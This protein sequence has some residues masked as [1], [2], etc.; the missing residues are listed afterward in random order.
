M[1]LPCSQTG[2]A[3]HTCACPAQASLTVFLRHGTSSG[4]SVFP[5]H[6]HWNHLPRL[7][8]KPEFLD[9]H[10]PKPLPRWFMM[11]GSILVS[12]GFCNKWPPSRWLKTTDIY[13]PLSLGQKSEIKMS[14][15]ASCPRVLW[16]EGRLAFSGTFGILW[17]VVAPSKLCLGGHVVFLSSLKSSFCLCLVVGCTS[18]LQGHPGEIRILMI[19]N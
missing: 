10:M 15:K 16:G 3:S 9:L 11:L 18:C 2:T 8:H 19:F 7:P 17:F 4:P 5:L 6:F 12:C 1:M 13:Y 14:G